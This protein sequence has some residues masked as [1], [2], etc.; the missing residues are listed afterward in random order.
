MGVFE[1]L[2]SAGGLVISVK[3]QARGACK[4]AFAPKDLVSPPPANP[5]P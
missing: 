1:V 3:A 4:V 5:K 2:G